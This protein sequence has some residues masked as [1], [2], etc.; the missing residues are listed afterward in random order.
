MNNQ[1]RVP[2]FAIISFLSTEFN[3]AAYSNYSFKL[4]VKIE[5]VSEQRA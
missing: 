1:I 2:N 5:S 4:E 3:T